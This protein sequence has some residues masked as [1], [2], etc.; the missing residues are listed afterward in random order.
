MARFRNNLKASNPAAYYAKYV[1]PQLDRPGMAGAAANVERQRLL[2]T[3]TN[4]AVN[5]GLDIRQS[6]GTAVVAMPQGVPVYGKVQ[7]APAPSGGGGGGG[8]GGGV[9]GPDYASQIQALNEQ[10]QSYR[11]QAEQIIAQGD[12][13]VKELENAD[14]QRQKAAELQNRLTIQ[15][16]TSQARGQAAP[17]LRIAQ[18]S[19][20]PQTAGTQAFKRRDKMSLAPIQSTAGI[21]VPSGSVLNI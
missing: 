20:P 10:A 19:Q 1:A 6:P 7:A 9:G 3:I 15:A 4:Q 11:T 8:G 5:P 2:K 17:N 16:Q 12:A 18:A 13:K 21:N 14:L